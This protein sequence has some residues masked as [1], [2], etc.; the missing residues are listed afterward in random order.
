MPLYIYIYIYIYIY[1]Y[2]HTHTYIHI[3]TYTYIHTYIQQIPP[4]KEVAYE[5]TYRPLA[6]T[7]TQEEIDAEDAEDEAAE[8]E[9]GKPRGQSRDGKKQRRPRVYQGSV[10]IPLP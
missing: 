1:T 9:G 5:L 8:A 6:M 2:I 3:Y 7:A 10:F 4:G